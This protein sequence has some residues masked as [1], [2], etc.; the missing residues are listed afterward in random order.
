MLENQGFPAK[1]GAFQAAPATA[2]VRFAVAQLRHAA[3]CPPHHHGDAN[4]KHAW[5]FS[6]V[7]KETL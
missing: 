4:D 1:F 2:P 7:R 6:S 3:A 5:Q